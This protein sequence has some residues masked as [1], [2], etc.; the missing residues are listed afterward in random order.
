MVPAI[1]DALRDLVQYVQF[2]KCEKHPWRSFLNCTNVT[3][4][5]NASHVFQFLCSSIIS[6]TIYLIVR[7]SKT[8]LPCPP[9]MSR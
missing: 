4:S 8:F 5:R 6:L 1:C 2:K 7:R 9:S 3:K